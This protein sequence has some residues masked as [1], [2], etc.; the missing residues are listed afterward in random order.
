MIQRIHRLFFYLLLVLL[1]T[2]LGY[3]F[4]PEWAHVL[5]R[6]VDYLSPTL[7]VTD[8][9]IFCVILFW[10]IES[11]SRG[12]YY[13]LWKNEKR[14]QIIHTIIRNTKYVIPPLVFIALNIW[15]A[16]NQPAALYKWLKVVEFGFLAWYIVKT[17]PQL[18][19]V[20]IFLSVGV[21]YSSILA[22]AQFMLQHSVGGMFWWLGERTFSVDTPGIARVDSDVSLFKLRPYATFPHPNVLGGFLAV[23][24]PLIILQ[25]RKKLFLWSSLGLGTIALVLTFSRSAWAVGGIAIAFAI[26]RSMNY[27]LQIKR[28]VRIFVLLSIFVLFFASRFM[29]HNSVSESVVVRQE[30]NS[31]AVKIWQQSPI[32]GV[33][34]GNFLIKLPEFLPKKSVYYLQPVHNIYLLILTETG[35]IGLVLFGWFI[36]SIIRNYEAGIMNYSLFTILLLGLVDHYPLTLQQGQLLFTLVA[37]LALAGRGKRHDKET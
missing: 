12:T 15:F 24:L 27:E 1:P 32:A 6:R 9:L 25:I 11:V 36:I 33:G 28:Y 30:L 8:I 10:A 21:F 31:A 19:L 26:A 18:S 29:I 17:K 34:L 2:Q 7:Y 16:S 3:H 14:K 20:T 22:I 35:F 23:T 13:E 4:W 5:G 37:G